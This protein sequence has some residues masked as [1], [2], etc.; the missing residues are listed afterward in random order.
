M[1]QN[2]PIHMYESIGIMRCVNMTFHTTKP[3]ITYEDN[4]LTHSVQTR[5]L[6]LRCYVA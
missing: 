6:R 4:V 3:K 1:C 5:S 2:T